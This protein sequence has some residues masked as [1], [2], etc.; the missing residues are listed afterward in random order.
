MGRCKK[1]KSL[2]DQAED[3]LGSVRP[4]VESAFDQAREFVEDTALP[5]L[6]DARDKAGPVAADARGRAAAN[7]ADL[8]VKAGPVAADARDRAVTNFADLKEKAA[9]VVASGAASVAEK[10][11]AARN[12]ADAKVSS[13]KGEQPKKGGKVK[14]LLLFGAVAGGVAVLAKKLQGGNDAADNWQS[15]YTPSPPPPS[16]S[17]KPAAPAPADETAP[18]AVVDPAAPADDSA[19][20]TPGEALS[21]ATEETHAVTTP[22]APAEVIA[23]EPDPLTDP[24]PED[25]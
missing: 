19:G 7:L 17:P 4:H 14:K 16:P 24:L 20:A 8:K 2:L 1:K 23:I 6:H 13:I 11:S 22:D 5:A 15:S 9:P 10:A 21:D 25:K 12:A 18:V 3:L